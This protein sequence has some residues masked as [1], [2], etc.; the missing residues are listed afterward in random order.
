MSIVTTMSMMMVKVVDREMANERERE[1]KEQMRMNEDV[2][3]SIGNGRGTMRT[4]YIKISR[5]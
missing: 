3:F 5:A 4:A 2:L 1:T